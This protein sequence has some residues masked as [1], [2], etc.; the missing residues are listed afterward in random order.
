MATKNLECAKLLIALGISPKCREERIMGKEYNYSYL[1]G[2][3]RDFEDLN[4]Q[5]VEVFNHKFKLLYPG[6][7]KTVGFVAKEEDLSFTTEFPVRFY[8][9]II[10]QTEEKLDEIR[11]SGVYD[12]DEYHFHWN[13]N[14]MFKQSLQ[15]VKSALKT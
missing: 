13:Q 3:E 1:R 15:R 14:M 11:G 2:L 7:V 6:R 12:L 5:I 9:D 8:T 10:K 4:G